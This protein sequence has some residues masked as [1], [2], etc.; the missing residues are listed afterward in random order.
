MDGILKPLT[1]LEMP[2]T[3]LIFIEI[4]GKVECFCLIWGI[5]AIFSKKDDSS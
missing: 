2:F 5:F 3:M 1:L 4:G